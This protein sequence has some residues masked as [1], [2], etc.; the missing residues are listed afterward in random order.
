ML[1]LSQGSHQSIVN[2]LLPMNQ[3][4]PEHE[5]ECLVIIEQY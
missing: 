5:N 3:Q 1:V 2:S 4:G